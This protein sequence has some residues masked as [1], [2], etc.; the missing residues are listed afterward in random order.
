MLS[1]IISSYQDHFYKQLC[2]SIG[3]TI[4]DDFPYEL[5]K[6]DNPNLMGICEA[7]NKGASKANYDHF[8][9]L[10]EDVIFQTK[11]W[12]N[13]LMK[14]FG[15][16]KN[17]GIL[18]IAGTSYKSRIPVGWWSFVDYN[19]LHIDQ[20]TRDKTI[21][22]HRLKENNKAIIVDGVFL[23][24]KREVWLKKKFNEKNK[25]FHGYDIEISLDVAKN[26]QNY[27]LSD[28]LLTHLS[29]GTIT[30]KWLD[31]II[32][33]YSRHKNRSENTSRSVEIFSYEIFFRYL[34]RFKYS[35]SDKILFF[36]KFYNPALFSLRENYKILHMFFY[37]LN[38]KN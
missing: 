37:Y 4:G 14:A 11:D 26:H 3:S 25:E 21:A 16:L 13:D 36:L 5:V 31:V 12:G 9:F 2:D 22:S 38:P 8:L 30:K 1:I 15:T 29:S 32:S 27:V 7:Y 28:I 17:P 18:G 19:F 24:M 6:I 10:H 33:I 23:A 20:L 34:N 35:K